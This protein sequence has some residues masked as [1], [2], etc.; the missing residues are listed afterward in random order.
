M[1]K[2]NRKA[3]VDNE[4]E[5]EARIK[6]ASTS[7]KKGVKQSKLR[8]AVKREAD[9]TDGKIDRK[10]RV[11]ETAKQKAKVKADE[12]K[13]S[14]TQQGHVIQTHM[15]KGPVNVQGLADKTGFT[16]ERCQNHVEYEVSKGRATINKKGLVV[17]NADK[18][19]KYRNNGE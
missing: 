10:I 19:P 9:A 6:K 3:V 2:R 17:V 13:L 12:A 7:G 11:A 4:A 14:R 5:V 16:V 1:I 8:R 18:Q 15:Q